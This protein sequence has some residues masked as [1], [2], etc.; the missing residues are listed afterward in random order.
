MEKGHREEFF[1]FY[2]IAHFANT[3]QPKRISV[4]PLSF[5]CSSLWTVPNFKGEIH[6]VTKFKKCIFIRIT[7]MPYESKATY[8]I[9]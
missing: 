1:F 6:F 3:V 2:K 9:Y 4:P 8:N 7:S 5:N